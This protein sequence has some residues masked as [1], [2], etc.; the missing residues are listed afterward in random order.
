[1]TT[2][3]TA[4]LVYVM[5]AAYP[6]TYEK[7]TNKDFE[8][9]ILA[10]EM[11]LEDY[12]YQQASAGLKTYLASDTKGFPPSPG[13]VVDCIHKIIKPQSDELT[14]LEAWALV[15]RAIS[16]SIYNAETE[17]D[18]LPKAV[19]RAIGSPANL[20]EM[21]SLDIEQVETVEQSHF[22]RNYEAMV[23]RLAEDAKMPASVLE[24]IRN[25]DPQLTA[26]PAALLEA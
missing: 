13:Q 2:R 1:M 15:R 22:I 23:K 4:Q 6:K 7:F 9:L 3:E 25:A 17:F 14:G 26:T 11:V 24:L 20:R 12:T 18:R 5:R 19:Q 16:N 10:W 8:N 21:A